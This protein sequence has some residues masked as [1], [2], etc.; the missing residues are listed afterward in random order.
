MRK[1]KFAKVMEKYGETDKTVARKMEVNPE[2]VRKWKAHGIRRRLTAYAVA[3]ALE[4]DHRDLLEN[5][6]FSEG[7]D[8]TPCL[9]GLE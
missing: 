2:T 6:V 9:P 1:T 4:C 7:W 8:L 5:R 3:Y